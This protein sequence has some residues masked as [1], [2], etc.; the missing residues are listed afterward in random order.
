MELF[1]K[2]KK[3]GGGAENNKT[4]V[5]TLKSQNTIWQNTF[6]FEMMPIEVVNM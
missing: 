1:S 2:L 4:E 5:M 6:M 3:K